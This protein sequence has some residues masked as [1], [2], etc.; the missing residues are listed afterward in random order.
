MKLKYKVA[1]I[2]DVAEEFRSLYEQ[3]SDGSW[4]LSVDG[5]A[6]KSRLDEFRNNNV[7]LLK[8][9][10]AFK[11]LDP[12]KVKELIE[13]ERKLAEKKLIDAGDIEGLVAQRV[14]AM[15]SDYEKKFTE[16]S[17]QLGLSTRQLETLMVDNVVREHSTKLGVA[18]TAVDDVILRAKSL[19]KVKD[20][21]PQALDS[22]G[23]TIYGKDGTASL[24]VAEWIGG[25]KEQA[26]HLFMASQGSGASHQ[27]GGKPDMSKMSASQK[28]AA[29]LAGGS[30]ILS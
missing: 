20:G 4:T 13:T 7:D 19:F 22:E 25:L 8:K 21:A 30:S 18:A 9:L 16:M 26:P 11:D 5:A 2:E 27:Q 28:I 1:K 10:E 29:G 24:T 23:K 6:D 17:E 15:K 3:G 14:N 12:N